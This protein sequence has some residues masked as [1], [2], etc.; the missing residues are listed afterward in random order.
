VLARSTERRAL[1]AALRIATAAL[2]LDT[3]NKVRDAGSVLLEKLSNYR[4]VELALSRG[5]LKPGLDARLGVSARIEGLTR[6]LD[7][8]VL[9][10]HSGQ[11]LRVNRFQQSFWN[12]AN[13]PQTWV[14]AS[15]P[16]ASGKTFLVLQWLLN[17]IQTSSAIVAVYLAPT[18]ALV[19][20]IEESLNDLL[21]RNKILGID[22]TSLPLSVKYNDAL[23][24]KMKAIFILTQ[25]RLH[26]LANVLNDGLK[27]DLLVADEAHKVG[28]RN[29]GV[30][31][32]DALERVSRIN[33]AMKVVFVSPATQN[34]E[35]LLEDA[36]PDTRT[37]AV[38]SDSPTVLQNVI[39]ATQQPRRTTEWSLKLRLTDGQQFPIGTLTLQGRPTSLKKKLALIAASAG[40]KGGT[41]VYTNGPAEAEEVALLISQLVQ[42]DTL[43]VD[44]E[45]AALA[46]LA[47]RGIHESYQLAPVVRKGV[48]FHY[49]NMP[50]LLREEIERL[51]RIGK[52][53]FLVCTSTLIEGVNLSCRTIVVR[54]PRKG[55]GQPMEPHDFWNLAGRAGRWG[56]EFQGNIICVDPDDKAA[57]PEGVPLRKRYPIQRE[58]DSIFG[59]GQGL[60]Q[61]IETRWEREPNDYPKIL[62]LNR[63]A[64]I[65]LLPTL[66]KAR[67]RRCRL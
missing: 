44:L 40:K 33:P 34:P 24:G 26:L 53:R 6:A 23:A 21:R 15:A 66:E 19:S 30:V 54:G 35:T 4:A 43:D 3:E 56:N 7:D 39:L 16:T 67:S 11:W 38:D 10:E 1:E 2:S 18:R 5:L 41:L 13:K 45:L 64:L 42:P 52:I 28:D 32:Q 50:S 60:L 12:E 22:V 9:V 29:R 31:L 25:E 47:R 58:T 61:F 27:I 14:S 55:V 17:E 65:F 20:E 62:S 57:W 48:A 59:L 46:D 37:Q 49:G 8:S 63:C 51:F 36:P